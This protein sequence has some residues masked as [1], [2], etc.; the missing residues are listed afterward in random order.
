LSPVLHITNGDSAGGLIQESD[1]GGDVLPWRDVLHEGPVP[2][3]LDLDELSMVRAEY[4]SG[5]DLGDLEQLRKDFAERDDAL[6]RFADYD[7]VV[8]WFEWDL[9]DQLQLI[10]LLDFFAG[11]SPDDLADTGTELSLIAPRGY[12]GGLP[13]EDLPVLMDG[14]EPITSDMLDLG[15]QAW[16]SFR[17]SDPRRM[18]EMQKSETSALPFLSEALLRELEEYPSAENGLSRSE[19]Q[20]LEVVAQSPQNFSEIFRGVANREERV[21]CGDSIMA[22]YI[23]RMSDCETPLITYQSGD[24]I[25]APR[26]DGDTRA[27][28]NVTYQSGDRILAPRFDGDTRAFRNAEMALTEA[29]RQVLACEKDWIAMG[30]S[31]RWLGGVHLA[32]RAATWRWNSSTGALL[33]IRMDPRA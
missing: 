7:E 16:Q 32:G 27:F 21:F 31:D 11:F 20:I 30:G 14:R 22:G 1:I 10:Q 15:R 23:Q 29:G 8:L 12:I 3:D 33:E 26:F 5:H 2:A 6:R 4:L 9:Y 18:H 19:R 25:L 24:R 28:R 17:S 13:A